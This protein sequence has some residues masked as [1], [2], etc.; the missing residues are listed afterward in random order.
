MSFRTQFH[1]EID[2]SPSNDVKSYN[3]KI[4]HKKLI[5]KNVPNNSS[6][7]F[8]KSLTMALKT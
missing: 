2:V 1:P 8:H 3:S 5:K 7:S 6:Y 4:T